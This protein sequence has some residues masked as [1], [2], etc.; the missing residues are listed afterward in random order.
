MIIQ[1]FTIFLV[2][3]TAWLTPKDSFKKK[4]LK[5]ERV[6]IAYQNKLNIVS[7]LYKNK[8]LEFT[9]SHVFIRVFKQE[10]ELELW[11]KSINSKTF[12]KIKTFKICA[13]SGTLGPKSMAGDGQV[14]EGLYFID[15]FNPA[16]NYHLSL[17][18]N[19]P[20]KADKIRAGLMP[21]G[22]DIFIHGECVTIG[23]IPLTNEY[24]EEVYIACVEAKESLQKN[25]NVEIYP[26]RLTSENKE[27][28]LKKYSKNKDCLK[29]WNTLQKSY[30]YFEK[31]KF[32]IKYTIDTKGNY[33]LTQ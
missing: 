15:R 16:S 7:N 14:P 12:Y 6:K 4:Q 21:T 2:A 1:Y 5:Y 9:K 20:N 27:K 29:I 26:C 22:G 17:G 30:D 24:I 25:I 3:L 19:Y 18:I 11:A 32:P 8:S 10:D 33:V 31:N 28:I 13:K 23:C